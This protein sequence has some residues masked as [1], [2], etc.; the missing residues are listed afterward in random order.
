VL[1]SDFNDFLLDAWHV[2]LTEFRA[3]GRNERDAI[4]KKVESWIADD[5]V[6]IHPKGRTAF[7]APNHFFVTASSNSDDAALIGNQDRKWA[8]H[9][10]TAPQ[11]T[12]AQNAWVYNFLNSARAPG[13]LRRYFLNV[14]TAGFAPSA[15][16]PQTAARA[17]MVATSVASDLE[18]LQSAFEER[19]GPFERDMVI[20]REV[21]GF[22]HK[23]C[24]NKPNME[25][26]KKLLIRPPFN[27]V[28]RQS[29]AGPNRSLRYIVLYNHSR[30]V[31]AS[32]K[33][34]KA[35]LDGD[36]IAM[37]DDDLLT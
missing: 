7:S 3:S 23:H 14:D 4:S 12:E 15:R 25:R 32:G 30:W 2:N 1:N 18:F 34:V 21:M 24:P 13:V 10:L 35:H 22:V 5:V 9:E 20:T 17:A 33:D 26:I 37:T 6:S 36:N 16:A 11:F 19:I 29:N 28:A 27:G 31:G 8:I